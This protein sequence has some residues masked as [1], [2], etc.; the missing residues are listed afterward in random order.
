MNGGRRP[1]CQ[2]GVPSAR[3]SGAPGGPAPGGRQRR[4]RESAP[5]PSGVPGP[6]PA[7]GLLCVGG[8]GGGRGV[9]SEDPGR[10]DSGLR[11]GRG[12]TRPAS[13]G[14]VRGEGVCLPGALGADK[15]RPGLIIASRALGRRRP[16]PAAAGGR[17]REK[18][19][20][21]PRASAPPAS[22]ASSGS[23]SAPAPPARPAP[24]SGSPDLTAGLQGAFSTKITW[25]GRGRGGQEKKKSQ[26]H[27]K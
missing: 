13:H 20:P 3:G 7:R 11:A 17:P 15:A 1:T 16:G 4:G 12:R 18:R 22:R 9:S 2:A 5:G 27:W 8:P 26:S 25:M 10:D 14:T 19:N 23:L 21:A 24:H 6:H